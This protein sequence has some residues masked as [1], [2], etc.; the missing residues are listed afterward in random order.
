MDLNGPLAYNH[1]ITSSLSPLFLSSFSNHCIAKSSLNLL[2]SSAG[3]LL[4]NESAG[5]SV[6]PS[7]SAAGSPMN[8]SLTSSIG[9]S[10]CYLFCSWKTWRLSMY[11][12]TNSLSDFATIDLGKRRL[13]IFEDQDQSGRDDGTLIRIFCSVWNGIISPSHAWSI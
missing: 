5:C 9:S 6:F 1:S 8:I 3:Q 4:F 12:P 10:S 11:V 13:R 2:R 7:A